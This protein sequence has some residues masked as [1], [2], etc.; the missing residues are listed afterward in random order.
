VCV[1]AHARVCVCVG[2]VCACVYAVFVHKLLS[3][4]ITY[5][6]PESDSVFRPMTMM[7]PGG[8]LPDKRACAYQP[9]PTRCMNIHVNVGVC[10]RVICVCE[11]VCLVCKYIS[12]QM[13][14]TLT[15]FSLTSTHTFSLSRYFNMLDLS[16]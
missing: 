10:A 4:E 9:P 3:T 16:Y 14:Y 15:I 8:R 2:H 11:S 6:D 1:C 5:R 13:H 12:T 7:T